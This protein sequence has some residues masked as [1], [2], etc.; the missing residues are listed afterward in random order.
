M[1]DIHDNEDNQRQRKV[2]FI[3]LLGHA[4]FS[5]LKVLASPIS[6]SDLTLEAIMKYLIGHFHPQTIEITERFKFFKKSQGRQKFMAQLQ[7]CIILMGTSSQSYETN[8]F[9]GYVTQ[10][11][12]KNCCVKPS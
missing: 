7:R 3:T 9:A 2:L 11:A 4:T 10:S 5:K 12:N 8:L 6:V 1:N